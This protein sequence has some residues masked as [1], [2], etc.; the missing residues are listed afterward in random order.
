MDIEGAFNHTYS[1][2][3]KTAMIEQGMPIAVVDWT[4][5]MLGDRN[6]TIIKE[7]TTHRGVVDLGCPQ[8]GVL[9][10]LLCSD[11]DGYD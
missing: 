7:N 10:L 11:Q 2:V 9:S 5:H 6:I 8:E 1:V 3:I 4:R